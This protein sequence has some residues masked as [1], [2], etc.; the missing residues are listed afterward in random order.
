MSLPTIIISLLVAII[1]VAIARLAYQAYCVRRD[2]IRKTAREQSLKQQIAQKAEKSVN[3]EDEKI[4]DLSVSG[5][6]SINDEINSCLAM[7]QYDEA[8]KWSLQ[9]IETRPEQLEFQVKLAEVYWKAGD[10]EQFTTLFE[11]LY[12]KLTD[13]TALNTILTNIAKE[14]IPN[15]PLLNC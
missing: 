13:E 8:I 4:F 10:Q 2:E 5:V 3:T 9:L 11:E 7:G 1:L 6:T 15:H 14:Y 12:Q